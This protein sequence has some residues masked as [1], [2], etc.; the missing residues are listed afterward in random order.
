MEGETEVRSGGFNRDFD[1]GALVSAEFVH[2]H[3][4]PGFIVPT[5]SCSM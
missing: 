2:D 4:V 5:N 3:D 1:G